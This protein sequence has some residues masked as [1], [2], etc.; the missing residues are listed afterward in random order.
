MLRAAIL[1]G[2]SLLMETD[3]RKTRYT[4]VDTQLGRFGLVKSG[5]VLN[6][7]EQ[8]AYTVR[9][10][11]HFSFLREAPVEGFPAD[12]GVPPK[13]EHFDLSRLSW[14]SRHVFLQVGR[15]NRQATVRAIRQ[16]EASGFPIPVKMGRCSVSA[17]QEIILET[18]RRASWL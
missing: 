3:M 1:F 11:A 14:G 7:T 8:E 9:G 13:G 5:A 2:A 17:M 16:L 6:L 18:A 15:M 4:G 12:P 10:D